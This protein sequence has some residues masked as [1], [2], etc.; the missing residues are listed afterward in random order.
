MPRLSLR[1][2]SP[3]SPLLLL[4]TLACSGKDADT[5]PE[6]DS[7]PVADTCA[8]DDGCENG[9][10]CEDGACVAGDRDNDPASATTLADDGSG[11]LGGQGTIATAGD[12]DWYQFTSLGAQFVRVDTVVGSSDVEEDALDTVVTIYDAAGNLLAQEDEHP[13]GPVGTYDSVAFAYLAEPGTY[14][15]TV[16]DVQ[17]RAQ[18]DTGYTLAVRDLGPGGDEADALQAAGYGLGITSA[19]SWYA[20]PVV[21]SRGD[22]TDDTADY[23]LL[24]LPWD[25]TFVEFVG[26]TSPNASTLTPALTLYD[27]DGGVVM[28]KTSPTPDDP[29]GVVNN[30]GRTYVLKVADAEGAMGPTCWAVLFALVRDAGYGNPREVEPNDTTPGTLAMVDRQPDVGAWVSGYG[31]GHVDTPTDVDAWSFSFTGDDA[32]LSLVYGAQTYGGLLLAHAEIVDGSGTV[33]ASSDATPGTDADIWNAGPVP[34]GTYTLRFSGADTNTA[35]GESAF[36][37][38]AVSASTSRLEP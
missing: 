7:T 17:G 15:V 18:P 10:I 34:A 33:V 23:A 38:F 31:S 3:A 36:Y 24:D 8:D 30:Q 28:K 19:D 29:A 16:E 4:A 13:A 6:T 2:L 20:I 5:V 22:G 37:Q 25:D 27:T 21:L 32:F 26:T 14:T 35:S 12:M 9:Q 11:V 1:A